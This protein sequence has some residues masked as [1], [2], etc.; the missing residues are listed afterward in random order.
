MLV[1]VAAREDAIHEDGITPIHLE[2]GKDRVV[3]TRVNAGR[4]IEEANWSVKEL[5]L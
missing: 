3:L 2:T 5:D 1:L 4:A